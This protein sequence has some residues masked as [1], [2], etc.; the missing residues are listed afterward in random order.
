VSK[1]DSWEAIQ[2]ELGEWK[3]LT[4]QKNLNVFREISNAMKILR[5]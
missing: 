3:K 5:M 2:E 1:G 4:E